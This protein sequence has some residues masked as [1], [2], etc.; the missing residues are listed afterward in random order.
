[1][2]A[3]NQ[4]DLALAAGLAVPIA[5]KAGLRVDVDG[6]QFLHRLSPRGANTNPLDHPGLWQ[7][8]HQVFECLHVEAPVGCLDGSRFGENS[9]TGGVQRMA[10][11]AQ[12]PMPHS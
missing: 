5:I 4:R 8:I 10:G 9:R 3:L 1:M 12:S 11:T 7:G 6:V 2:F